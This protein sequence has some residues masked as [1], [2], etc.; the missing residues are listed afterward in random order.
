LKFQKLFVRFFQIDFV[1]LQVVVIL[2]IYFKPK[3]QF[4]FEN[5]T[6]KTNKL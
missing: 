2:Q 3:I 1:S 6:I 5:I 4:Q